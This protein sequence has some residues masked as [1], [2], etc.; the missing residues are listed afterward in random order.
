MAV[1]FRGDRLATGVGHS[2]QQGEMN[3]ATNALKE[4]S[5]NFLPQLKVFILQ[6]NSRQFL[7]DMFPHLLQTKQYLDWRFGRGDTSRSLS[8]PQ[9]RDDVAERHP[10]K[11]YSDSADLRGKKHRKE[12]QSRSSL[13]ESKY[14]KTR[15]PINDLK[16]AMQSSRQ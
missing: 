7:A 10:S 6:F 3:A 14:S 4:K 5:G 12:S 16:R 11:R 13:N 2:I 15:P 9:S 1:Y 8:K